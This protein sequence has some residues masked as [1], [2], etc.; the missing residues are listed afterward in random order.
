[1][2]TKRKTVGEL[3]KR[4]TIGKPKVVKTENEIVLGRARQAAIVHIERAEVELAN[5]LALLRYRDPESAI[6]INRLLMQLRATQN[7]LQ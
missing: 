4:R 5:A 3:N 7:N 2:P 6:F 1:M